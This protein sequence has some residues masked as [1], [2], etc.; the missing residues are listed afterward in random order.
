MGGAKNTP[1]KP[2]LTRR[3]AYALAR[4][5]R[6]APGL[7]VVFVVAP[8]LAAVVADALG[9]S[10]GRAAVYWFAAFVAAHRRRAVRRW[11]VKRWRLWRARRAWRALTTDVGERVPGR[12]ADVERTLAG[13]RYRVVM[14]PGRIESD[15]DPMRVASALTG[16]RASVMRASVD[17]LPASPRYVT[18]HA[19]TRDPLAEV[20][21]PPEPTRRRVGEPIPVG[22]DEHG[23]VVTVTLG[24]PPHLVAG[25]VPGGGKSTFLHQVVA[26]FL[27]DESA[28]AVLMD[29]KHV[30]LAAWKDSPR[31][32]FI[33]ADLSIAQYAVQWVA[34]EMERRYRYMDEMAEKLKRPIRDVL[35]L[36]EHLR[37]V[38]VLLLVDECTTFYDD[39]SRGK[40]IRA[41]VT[42]VMR[43]ARA[44]GISVVVATQKPTGE[45]LPTNQR[46][47][48]EQ[49]VA[50]K[51]TTLP[52]GRAILGDDHGEVAMAVPG[53]RPGRFAA[54]VRGRVVEGR[55]FSAPE[56]WLKGA[57][58]LAASPPRGGEPSSARRFDVFRSAVRAAARPWAKAEPKPPE[59]PPESAGEDAMDAS[60][61]VAAATTDPSPYGGGSAVPAATVA[62]APVAPSMPVMPEPPA[63]PAAPSPPAAAEARPRNYNTAPA[64]AAKAAK[65]AAAKPPARGRGRSVAVGEV[66]EGEG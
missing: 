40:A 43:Q 12:V 59:A 46:D 63:A 28:V 23:D 47:I 44:A 57:V 6:D 19:R 52:M 38:K 10:P 1:K 49:R 51:V 34:W 21:A 41:L 53:E 66:S 60:A 29:G 22:V 17:R 18:V 27:A 39:P 4:V 33:G 61:T 62:E 65:R 64:R 2:S 55:S 7:V 14:P 56:A 8:L 36:P 16:R 13:W 11:T 15:L 26:G 31:V 24:N 37:P 48:A 54:V 9:Q 3:V 32:A 30:E 50:F 20:L 58:K 42:H 45:A 5:S 35:D 25:G